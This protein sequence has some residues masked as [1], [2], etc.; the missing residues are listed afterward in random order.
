MKGTQMSAISVSK[1]IQDDAQVDTACYRVIKMEMQTLD[2][3]EPIDH[4]DIQAAI[5]ALS[6]PA[7]DVDYQDFRRELGLE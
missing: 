3:P 5:D 6:D 1:R 2:P 7:S 4:D